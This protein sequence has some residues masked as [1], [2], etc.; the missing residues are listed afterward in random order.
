MKYKFLFSGRG[1]YIPVK[2]MTVGYQP[3]AEIF[4]RAGL[5]GIDS[6]QRKRIENWSF[7]YQY[8]RGTMNSRNDNLIAAPIVMMNLF[9]RKITPFA[10]AFMIFTSV[11]FFYPG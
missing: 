5:A 2:F 1:M 7:S 11:I 8:G 6:S 9:H 4:H 3:E 10:V